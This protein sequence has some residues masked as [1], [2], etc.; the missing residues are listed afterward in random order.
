MNE[1]ESRLI[2][3]LRESNDTT[4]ALEVALKLIQEFLVPP[5]DVPCTTSEPTRVAV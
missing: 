1:T 5:Q 3:L 4:T 2:Y